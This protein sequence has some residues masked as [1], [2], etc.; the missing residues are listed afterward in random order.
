MATRILETWV[1]SLLTLIAKGSGWAGTGK[2]GTIITTGCTVLAGIWD[3]GI[4]GLTLALV[5]ED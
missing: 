2:V 4:A 3:T 1:L 5:Q